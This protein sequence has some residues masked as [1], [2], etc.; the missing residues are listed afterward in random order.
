MSHMLDA[1]LRALHAKRIPF[2]QFYLRTR[3]EWQRMATALHRRWHL[4]PTVTID[5]VE[6][7]MLLGAW[8]SIGKWEA[9]RGPM[10]AVFVVW[11]AHN[12]ATKWIHKQ[13]GCNLHTRKGVSQYAW[14]VS[15]M[16]RD[17]GASSVI[18]NYADGAPCADDVLDAADL[19]R[20]IPEAASTMAGRAALQL[21]IAAGGDVD[22]AARAWHADKEHRRLFELRTVDDAKRII[23]N[24][25]WSVRRTLTQEDGDAS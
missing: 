8:I 9:H 16:A 7:E 4:P 18:E 17:D 3:S 2:R 6:Q 15:S 19:L 20:A 21:F 5:D 10:L 12:H 11:G 23:E 14:C 25:V 1:E 13:R 22:Q 24:E